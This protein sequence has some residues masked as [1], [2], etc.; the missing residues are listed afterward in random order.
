MSKQA[1]KGNPK[2]NLSNMKKLDKQVFTTR[3]LTVEVE[4]N[5]FDIEIDE[6]F[7]VDKIDRMFFDAR[8]ITEECRELG[9]EYNDTQ[10]YLLIVVKHFTDIKF[11][12]KAESQFQLMASLSNHDIL[13]KIFNEFSQDELDKLTERVIFLNEQL[14]MLIDKFDEMVNDFTEQ[15]FDKIREKESEGNG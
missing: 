4:G 9:I 2:I 14:P 3:T 6:V 8:N 15:N 13:E 11:P 1:K 10:L 12:D 7:S 5:K